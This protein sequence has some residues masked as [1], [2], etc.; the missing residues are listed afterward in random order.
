M[1]LPELFEDFPGDVEGIDVRPGEIDGHLVTHR[2]RNG[3]RMSPG[4]GIDP[5]QEFFRRHGI[6]DESFDLREPFGILLV[7]AETFKDDLR[8]VSEKVE[9]AG[10]VFAEMPRELW[11][12]ECPFVK[13]ACHGAYYTKKSV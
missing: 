6:G 7:I 3:W 1:P 12:Q 10:I 11:L 5:L 13:L 9:N 4:K 8:M 2:D